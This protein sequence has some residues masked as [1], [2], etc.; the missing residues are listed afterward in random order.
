MAELPARSRRIIAVA[1]WA[2][3]LMLVA[4]AVAIYAGVFPVA[5]EVRGTVAG[6]LG[7]VAAVDTV[8]GLWFFRASL[9]S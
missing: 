9:T 3:A 8:L 7:A 2:G 5:P 6:V 4:L 1:L